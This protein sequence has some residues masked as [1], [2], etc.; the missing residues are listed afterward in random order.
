MCL[1]GGNDDWCDGCSVLQK[2]LNKY[3]T[4]LHKKV[5]SCSIQVSETYL[6][7]P[8]PVSSPS[9]VEDSALSFTVFVYFFGR[10][11]HLLVKGRV[12][13]KLANTFHRVPLPQMK[14]LCPKFSLLI[15]L[16]TYNLKWLARPPST[17]WE[18]V[19]SLIE[20]ALVLE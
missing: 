3:V 18:A 10:I 19:Y 11:S 7:I 14:Y 6:Q 5:L 12:S 20:R 2:F 1:V 9:L 15:S 8:P 4:Y 13:D 17:V 16:V